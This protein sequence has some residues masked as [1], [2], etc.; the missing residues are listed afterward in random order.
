MQSS[1]GDESDYRLAIETSC[2]RGSVALGSGKRVLASER[3][4]AQRA[5]AVELLPTVAG[6]C[7]AHS[8]EPAIVRVIFVSIGPG[9]FTGLR[10][11]VTAARFMAMAT[12][13]RLVPV[14][15]LEVIA[16]N[17]LDAPDPPKRVAVIVDA[18]RGR[19]YAAAFT[20]SGT[21]SYAA[22]TA[23]SEVELPAFLAEQAGIDPQCGVLG[24][25]IRQHGQAVQESGLRAL[26]NSLAEPRADV[27]YRLGSRQADRGQFVDYRFVLPHYIRRPEA[28]EKWATGR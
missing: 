11:G 2:L 17:A 3:F 19:A 20:Q 23:P 8:V 12:G 28:E 7:L 25:G 22:V 27:V 14:E 9:S 10:I 13:A 21:E 15:T 5:H 18:K 4:G 24:S 26:S 1:S 6:L 16:Q